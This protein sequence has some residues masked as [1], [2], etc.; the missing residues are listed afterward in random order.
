MDGLGVYTAD[1][2][3]PYALLHYGGESDRLT[4]AVVLY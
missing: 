2:Q 1:M 4:D 3:M